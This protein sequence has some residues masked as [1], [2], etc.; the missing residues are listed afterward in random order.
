[1]KR[2]YDGSGYSLEI[3]MKLAK[4]LLVWLNEHIREQD[5]EFAVYFHWRR[6]PP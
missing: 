1:L 3:L 4:F 6:P 5:Q 2:E